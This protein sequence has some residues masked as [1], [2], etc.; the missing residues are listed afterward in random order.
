MDDAPKS[1]G[2]ILPCDT[3]VF[4]GLSAKILRT[5]GVKL[6]PQTGLDCLLCAGF[7]RQRLAVGKDRAAVGK[8]RV[9]VGRKGYAMIGHLLRTRVSCVQRHAIT[10]TQLRKQ[11]RLHWHDAPERGGLGIQPRVGWPE[12]LCTVT[13]AISRAPE[14]SPS[15]GGGGIPHSDAAP[16]SGRELRHMHDEEDQAAR[17]MCLRKARLAPCTSHVSPLSLT[18]RLSPLI[19]RP[20]TL[21]PH[22]SPLAPHPSP[23]TPHP[24]PLA[25]HPSPLAP[26]PSPRALGPCFSPIIPWRSTTTGGA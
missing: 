11:A 8:D 20:S 17:T 15:A 23:L 26:H 21:A 16:K 24:S 9:A 5:F 12:G 18:P 22:P 2:S 14:R 4:G 10:T 3:G 19:P 25:P 6:S 7:A 1:G 13:S